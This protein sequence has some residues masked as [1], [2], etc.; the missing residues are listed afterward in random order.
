MFTDQVTLVCRAGDGGNGCSSFWREA[1]VPRGGPDGGDGGNGGNIV[2][3]ADRNLGSLGNLVGLYHWKAE[4][5]QHGKGSNRTGRCGADTVILVPPGTL[6]KDK[7][8]GHLLKDLQE[9]GESVIVARGGWGGRGNKKFATST[10]RAP[11]EC[12]DG[13]PGE[14]REVVLELKLI[15]DVGLVGKPN[16]GKSTLLSRV[17]RATPEIADYAFTTKYPNLGVVRVDINNEFV[18]ADIPGLIEGAHAGAGLGHEFLRHIE[19]TRLI[20]HMVEP[21][22]MDQSDPLSNYDQIRLELEK[23]DPRLAALPEIL[24]VTKAELPDAETCAE[25]LRETSGRDVHLISAVTGQ[26][27]EELKRM[28]VDRLAD[29]ET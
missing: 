14:K 18:L 6:V 12:E 5:G 19:R 28:V 20:V 25:L 7:Q 15:A 29:I 1:H 13:Q 24:C 16:A 22:P 11:R 23:Y 26:G 9:H 17:S 3:Q 27:L 10:D 4:R 8:H 2:I 21:N